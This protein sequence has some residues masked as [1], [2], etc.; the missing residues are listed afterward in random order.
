[1]LTRDK[2]SGLLARSVNDEGKKQ[3]CNL[4]KQKTNADKNVE[5]IFVELE[6]LTMADQESERGQSV[7]KRYLHQRLM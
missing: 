4:D 3:F 6:H 5:K 1:M 2:Q 7:I